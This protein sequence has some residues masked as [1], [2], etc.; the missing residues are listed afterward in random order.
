MD[1]RLFNADSTTAAEALTGIG[2]T[3][4]NGKAHEQTYW[5]LYNEVLFKY[6]NSFKVFLLA[7]NA[8]NVCSDSVSKVQSVRDV[9][10]LNSNK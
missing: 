7:A 8:K 5:F 10:P 6:G 1:Q 3:E 2:P 9:L 4:E